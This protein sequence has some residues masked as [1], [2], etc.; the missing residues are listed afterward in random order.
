MIFFE[1]PEG[2]GASREI[3]V[4]PYTNL[5]S[6]KDAARA[7]GLAEGTLA[8]LRLTG[9][10]PVYVKLGRR[11]AYRPE[12][13]DRWIAANLRRSTSDTAGL[14]SDSVPTGS[15]AKSGA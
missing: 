2:S 3:A 6:A 7:L 9:R 14:T 1:K 10:G 4:V 13:I 5:L 15:F 12:D 11:V 8:K